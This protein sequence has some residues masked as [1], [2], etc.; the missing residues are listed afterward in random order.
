MLRLS[1]LEIEDLIFEGV[2]KIQKLETTSEFKVYNKDDLSE[3]S[4][5][6]AGG[7]KRGAARDSELGLG[8]EC[9]SSPTLRYVFNGTL[10]SPWFTRQR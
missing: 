8:T 4:K 7:S 2:K 3:G 9:F 1:A 6:K 10:A 5:G